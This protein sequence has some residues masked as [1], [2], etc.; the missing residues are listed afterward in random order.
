MH[1]PVSHPSAHWNSNQ[2]RS[3]KSHRKITASAD[4]MGSPRKPQLS[5]CPFGSLEIIYATLIYSSH[6][7]TLMAIEAAGGKVPSEWPSAPLWNTHPVALPRAGTDPPQAGKAALK[8]SCSQFFQKQFRWCCPRREDVMC[9]CHQLLFCLSRGSGEYFPPKFR[10]TV[11]TKELAL[12][13][14]GL[15]QGSGPARRQQ[16]SLKR[17]R[18]E[19]V[20]KQ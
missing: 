4:S 20:G 17:R 1:Q 12:P 19:G 11:N 2:G 8:G 6:P 16:A 7:V 15:N 13:G 18:N 10:E 5:P 9:R 3:P 14:L